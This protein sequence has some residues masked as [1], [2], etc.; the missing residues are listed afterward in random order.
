MHRLGITIAAAA[1]AAATVFTAVEGRCEE[2]SLKAKVTGRE[3][4]KGYFCTVD[5][6]L[7]NKRDE[8]VWFLISWGNKLL[9]YDG[10]FLGRGGDWKDPFGE[11]AVIFNAETA[12]DG[13]EYS[14][15]NGIAIIVDYYGKDDFQAILLPPKAHFHFAGFVIMSPDPAR[16]ID[17]W[18]VKSLKVNDKTPLE[19]CLPYS[20]MS[21]K[22]VE[23][24]GRTGSGKQM[25]L[26]SRHSQMPHAKPY[27]DEEVKTVV[28][29]PIRRHVVPL[30]E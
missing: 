11:K 30:P 3:K 10:K 4:G 17:V 20:L 1:V 16:F 15:G 13:S 5:L 9:R 7:E 21:S 27:P 19:K 12:F 22:S 14:E 28:A 2:D 23:I 24:A 8:P 18:E 6:T 29:E 25:S 26:K